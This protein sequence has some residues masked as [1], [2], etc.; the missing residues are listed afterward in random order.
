MEQN[1]QRAD[2]ERRE[3][4]MQAAAQRQL[5]LEGVMHR[6]YSHLDYVQNAAD[7]LRKSHEKKLSVIQKA[8]E[9][10]RREAQERFAKRGEVMEERLKSGEARLV[11]PTC[12]SQQNQF[13][14]AR[15]E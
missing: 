11:L 5:S 14:G 4:L 1:K 2:T 10:R 6:R 15:P 12:L 9:L 7:R 13:G 8:K 3:S